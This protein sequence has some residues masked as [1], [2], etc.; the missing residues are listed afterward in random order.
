MTTPSPPCPSSSNASRLRYPV[1]Y[2]SHAAVLTYLQRSII[3]P[4]PLYVPHMVFLDRT[5]TIRADIAGE[6]EFFHD[7]EPN[8]RA[9]LDRMLKV[10][11]GGSVGIK[12]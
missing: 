4:R 3:D 9:Q 5:G 6:S 10:A 8:L 2:S 7:A 12:R 1:G 11:P